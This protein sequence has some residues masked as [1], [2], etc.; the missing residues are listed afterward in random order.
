MGEVAIRVEGGRREDIEGM[1]D[2]FVLQKC[3][4][5]QST[6]KRRREQSLASIIL[7]LIPGRANSVTCA[8]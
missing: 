8:L 5:H 2:A 1:A 4:L 6:D 3:A 7:R